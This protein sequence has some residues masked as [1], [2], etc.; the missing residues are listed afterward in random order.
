MV[1]KISVVIPTLNEENNIRE[2]LYH[3]LNQ[4]KK[5][6]EIVVV[7]N[8]STDKTTEIVK[9][10][11]EKFRRN[12]INLKLFYCLNGNQK[13]ARELGVKKSTGSIIGSLDADSLADKRWIITIHNYFRDKNLVGIGGKSHFRNKGFLF[14]L[15]YTVNYYIRILLNL[16]CI[17]GGNSAFRRSA[18]ISVRGYSGLEYL[19]KK[20]NISHAK[21]D[22][23]LSKSIEQIGKIKFCEDLNVSLL[24]RIRNKKKRSSF[25]LI[26][27]LKRAFFEVLYDYRI[28]AYFK[29][30]N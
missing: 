2:C 13:S 29:E 18:Y 6:Y 27:V 21:D 11:Q 19:R 5:P 25:V 17:G 10:L 7:D 14:N 20:K 4:V 26:A 1:D 23:F 12:K 8:G 28:N 15:F 16:Y 30:R 9:S 3:L 22:Y 24:Y